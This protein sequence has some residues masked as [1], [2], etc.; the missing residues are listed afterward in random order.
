MKPIFMTSVGVT[1]LLLAGLGYSVI[2]LRAENASLSEQVQNAHT[3][4][5]QLSEQTESNA[6]LR[7][8]F[9]QQLT[10]LQQQLS[11]SNSRL[12]ALGAQ[13]EEAQ[14]RVNP[15][16]EEL[17][18]RARTEVAQ[19]MPR[20]RRSAPG[21]GLGSLANPDMASTLASTSVPGLYGNYVESLGLADADQDLVMQAMIESGSMRYQMLDA[22]LSGNLTADD[23]TAL[24]GPDAILNGMSELLTN[25]QL[26]E[27]AQY[28]TVVKQQSARHVLAENLGRTGDTITGA[29]QDLVLDTILD[30]IYSV[31]NNNGAIVAAD[32]SMVT[33]YND[34]LAAYDRARTRLQDNLNMDQQ[35]QLDRFIESR[36]SG[37]DVLLE[38]SADDSGRLAIRNARVDPS[39][40]PN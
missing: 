6:R 30:E 22:L 24:F 12:T 3:Y 27:L 16:Y 21:S 10:Q 4:R 18:Q 40:L 14:S 26:S 23:A 35:D 9:Q 32:G 29:T 11:E 19:E 25:D 5:Q 39:E 28:D 1:G 8:E 7:L 38:A 13:L 33:A 20:Q 17:L 34:Q 36:S 37:V 31:Q 15:Q 2:S